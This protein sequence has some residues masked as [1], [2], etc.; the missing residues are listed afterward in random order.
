M[1]PLARIDSVFRQV[2]RI[3]SVSQV[4]RGILVKLQYSSTEL[5][6]LLFNVTSTY[7]VYKPHYTL[8]ASV[9]S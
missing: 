8:Y 5:G 3:D 9:R 2:T 4:S 6:L 1:L 7:K